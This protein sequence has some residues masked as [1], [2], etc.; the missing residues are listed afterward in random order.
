MPFV[1]FWYIVNLDLTV[2]PVP[3]VIVQFS[4]GYFCTIDCIF[5]RFFFN[6][7]SYDICSIEIDPRANNGAPDYD[8]YEY[9]KNNRFLHH[10]VES[11]VAIVLYF[12]HV[13]EQG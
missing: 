2:I 3:F 12:Y 6:D 9:S 8:T 11:N 7:I 1:H 5:F 4:S 13:Y 10:F